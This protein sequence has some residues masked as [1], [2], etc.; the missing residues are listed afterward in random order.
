MSAQSHQAKRCGVPWGLFGMIGLLVAA[1]QYVARHELDF[2]SHIPLDWRMSG[3]AASGQVAHCKLLCFGDS[4]VKHAV[5]SQ[6]I[7]HR[8]GRAA[9]CLAVIGGQP[10]SSYVLLRRALESGARPAAIVMNAFPSLLACDLRINERQWPELL[11]MCE[12]AELAWTA[13]DPRLFVTTMLA[14]V[15]PS[16]AARKEMRAA[17]LAAL[18]GFPNGSWQEAAAYQRNWSVNQGAQVVARNPRFSDDVGPID[19]HDSKHQWKCKPANA[20][21]LERFLALAAAHKIPVFWLMPTISPAWQVRREQTG[22]DLPY[23]RFVRSLQARFANLIVVDARHSGYDRTVFLDPAHL[24][25]RG[26]AVLSADLADIIGRHVA[27]TETHGPRWIELP[28]FRDR[29]IDEPL[30]DLDQ[31]RVA[32]QLAKGRRR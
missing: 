14:R 15:F 1:E 21:Y 9:Y 26:A 10:P 31:S 17:T 32:L 30:E 13:R 5:Q 16:V 3:R 19:A 4:E 29:P 25:R 27:R 12:C 28:A 6:V 8:L 11:T 18:G 23:V 22:L 24:D 7:A 20:A 2:T